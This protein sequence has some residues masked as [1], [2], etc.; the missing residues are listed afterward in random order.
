MGWNHKSE[1]ASWWLFLLLPI[2]AGLSSIILAPFINL[3]PIVLLLVGCILFVAGF[4]IVLK[5]TG[6]KD[7]KE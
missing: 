3:H 1:K 7:K 4:I 5:R 6:K 2:F